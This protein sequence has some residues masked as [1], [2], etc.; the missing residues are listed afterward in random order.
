MYKFVN[1]GIDV[2]MVYT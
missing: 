1:Q 2:Y